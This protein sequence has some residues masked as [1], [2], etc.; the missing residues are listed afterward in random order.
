MLKFWE[1]EG[2]EAIVFAQIWKS[3]LVRCKRTEESDLGSISDALMHCI[4]FRIDAVIITVVVPLK[5][6]ENHF[7]NFLSEG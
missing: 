3:F 5:S 7:R 1:T 2:L 4:F 6:S